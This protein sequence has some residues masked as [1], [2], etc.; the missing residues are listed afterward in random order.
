MK[1]THSKQNIFGSLSLI[2]TFQFKYSFQQRIVCNK[3]YGHLPM[4]C[5]S[6]IL[7]LRMLQCT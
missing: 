6:Q 7:R 5:L 2:C 3:A 4:I 1:P